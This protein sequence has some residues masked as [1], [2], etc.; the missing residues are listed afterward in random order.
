MAHPLPFFPDHWSGAAG[1]QEVT[2]WPKLRY[3][4]H[5]SDNDLP[6]RSRFVISEFLPNPR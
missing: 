5:T 6:E 4:D 3:L 2:L 1:G